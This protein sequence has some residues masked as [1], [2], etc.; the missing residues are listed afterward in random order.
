MKNPVLFLRIAS[1]MTFIHAVLH[2]VGGVFG[3]TEPGAAT[4]A[5]EA[6]KA[7]QFL[8]MGHMRSYWAF[9][10]GLGLGLSIFLTAESIIF[11]QLASLARRDAER[12][13]PLLFTF[14]AAY[15][16]FALNSNTYFFIGP[17]IV[18]VMIAA[19]LL[20]AIAVT[21]SSSESIEG[22]TLRA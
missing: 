21:K 16:L 19:S 17:V 15:S 4:I 5:V 14:A 8:L 7:N 22:T 2:T 3:R 6:M 13:R 12:V 1:V 20:L 18:E 9:Y 11:W 10:R